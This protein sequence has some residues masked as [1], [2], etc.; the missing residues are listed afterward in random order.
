MKQ[1]KTV[2]SKEDFKVGDLA[3]ITLSKYRGAVREIKHISDDGLSFEETPDYWI[4]FSFIKK[5]YNNKTK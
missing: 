5:V 1:L 2:Y 3:K 4:P